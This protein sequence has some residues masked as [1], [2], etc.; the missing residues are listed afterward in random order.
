MEDRVGTD[1]FKS[2]GQEVTVEVIQLLRRKQR[3][4]K[5]G[6]EEG[7][8]LKLLDRTSVPLYHLAL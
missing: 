3:V 5:D 2:F 7:M 6:R 8:R 1:K 4:K